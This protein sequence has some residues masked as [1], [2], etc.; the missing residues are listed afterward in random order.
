[1]NDVM[2]PTLLD[3]DPAVSA[4]APVEPRSDVMIS[5]RQVGKLYRLY[6]RPQD[7]LKEQLL[8]RFGKHFGR[9]FWALQD[10]SFEIRKGEAVGIIGRNGSGK[11]TLLQII[12]GTLA[13]TTGE[14]GVA[15]R[16]AAL[17]ELGSGFNFEFTGR[18]NVFLNGTVLGISQEEM[19][20][21]FS[22][23]AAFADIGEFIDQPVKLYSSGMVMRLAFAVQ[24]IIQKDILIV[25]E[26]LAVGDE[27]FQRKCMRTLEQFRDNGGTVLLVS[28]N[29]QAI[30]RQCERCLFLHNGQL[31]LDGPSKPVTDL[32]QRFIYGTPEQQRNMLELLREQVSVPVVVL[33]RSITQPTEDSAG[34]PSYLRMPSQAT[35]DPNISKPAELSYGSGQAEIFD[36]GMYDELNHRVNVIVVGQRYTWRYHVHFYEAARNVTFGM[37]IKTVDGV[38]VAGINNSDESPIGKQ[39]D[40]EGIVE[41]NFNFR[42]NLAPGTY[43]LNSGV[44]SDADAGPTFIHRRIDLYSIRVI[45]PD[46]KAYYGLAYLEPRIEVRHI[47]SKETDIDRI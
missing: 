45:S 7:R 15:G 30:I 47:R 9:P 20:A 6:D 14:A 18:E 11:S 21:R 2:I 34:E 29:A 8:W 1:M 23:I 17:L 41:V 40:E 46:G 13:P 38:D 37:M 22:E 5:V 24:A 35:F 39:I 43:Y 3:P 16:V 10:I 4:V 32:Y 36:E 19:D 28:H 27:A 25:D 12:A 26:A 44:M 33:L 42:T 31:V